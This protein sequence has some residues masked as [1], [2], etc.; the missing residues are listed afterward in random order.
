MSTTTKRVQILLDAKN[1]ASK[2]ISALESQLGGLSKGLGLVTKGAVIMGTAMAAVQFGQ[3]AFEMGRASSQSMR[4]AE[5]FDALA[6]STGTSS[7]AMLA[8]MRQ[9]AQ[10]TIDDTA[11]MLSANRAMLLGVA[12]NSEEMATLIEIAAARGKAMGMTTA[13]AFN[14]IVTGIGRMSPMILDNLGITVDAAQANETYAASLGKSADKLTDAEQKQA[15]LNAVI[16]DS[17]GLLAANA[18]Q[19]RDLAASF[20]RMDASI[21]N[22][23][24]ALGALFAPAAAVVA[25]Q[26]A[27]AVDGMVQALSDERIR[28]AQQDLWALGDTL[29]GMVE[30][31]LAVGDQAADA[32]VAGDIPGLQAAANQYQL[33][34][35]AIRAVGEEYNAAAAKTGAPLLD[36]NQLVNGTM[37]FADL[38]DA[39]RQAGD[40]LLA[41]AIDADALSAAQA[42]LR[43]QILET[44]SAMRSLQSSASGQLKSLFL[45]QVSSLG[46]EAAADAY[47][48]QNRLLQEQM[49]LWDA[50]NVSLE[51]QEFLARAFVDSLRG[52]NREV[53]QIATGVSEVDR[54]LE[55][56][57]GKTKGVIGES[58]NLD[59]GINPADFLPRPD[60]LNEDAR[61]LADV[62]VRGFDSPWA[63]Y[64]EREFPKLWEELTSGDDIQA[65]AARLLQQFQMGLRPELMDRDAIKERVRLMILGDQNAEALAREIA[66]E[67]A[68]EMG[69]SLQQAQA[70]ASGV[71]RGGDNPTG[72]QFGVGFV[73]GVA[74][75]DFGGQ[76]IDALIL[77][78]DN[79][80]NVV[81]SAG[82]RHARWYGENFV[83]VF[84][85]SVPERVVGV[86]AD[87]VTPAV[88]ERIA[89]ARSQTGTVD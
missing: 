7:Q 55:T 65:S 54:T 85:G 36:L 1:N 78:M 57:A 64:F 14:D 41:T 2:E 59:V 35:I 71:L 24:D 75:G 39:T 62:M 6:A 20:E 18:G 74:A 58:L 67:L 19:G 40:E 11:L 77:Q 33:L 10:G 8:A 3:M 87:L 34:Q 45:G 61:R 12:R 51:D 28:G 72:G 84:G 83:D 70:A 52:A 26:L 37:A 63:A 76:A 21:A 66:A 46:V 25:E 73:E 16:R 48:R 56:L 60:A 82:G 27:N 17:Q 42:R 38:E 81:R 4:T 50:Q 43:G 31:L 22:A 13:E 53:R 80:E 32:G 30:Q 79:A 49:A 44:V 69:V 23:K 47:A 86:L 68:G 88:M 9:A 15:L 29:S 89:A 5:A